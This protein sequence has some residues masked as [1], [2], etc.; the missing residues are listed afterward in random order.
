MI[1][2]IFH[3][4]TNNKLKIPFALWKCIWDIEGIDGLEKTVNTFSFTCKFTSDDITIIL[5]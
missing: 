2:Q 3:S 4:E 5:L 1:W